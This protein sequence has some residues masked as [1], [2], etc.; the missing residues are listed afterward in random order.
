MWNQVGQPNDSLPLFLRQTV[1]HQ[2]AMSCKKHPSCCSENIRSQIA[3]KLIGH[4][5]GLTFDIE[6]S[7]KI[8]GGMLYK[9]ENPGLVRKICVLGQNE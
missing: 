8:I 5:L 9:M 7:E 2:R 3:V 1:P 4:P 6:D